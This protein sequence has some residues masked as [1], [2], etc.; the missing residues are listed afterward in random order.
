MSAAT[1]TVE[2]LL[3][4]HWTDFPFAVW[5]EEWGLAGCL[6]LLGCYLMLLVWALNLANEARDRF[7]RNLTLG[8]TGLLFWHITINIAMVSGIAPVVGVTLPLISY[9]GSSLLTVLAVLGLLMNVS[10]RRYS[11]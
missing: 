5:A 2:P 9:G 4:E 8:C 1:T 3:P 6:V 11:Y 10:I 7:A